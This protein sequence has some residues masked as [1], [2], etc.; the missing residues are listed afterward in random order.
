MG[1]NLVVPLFLL[2][3]IC[4]KSSLENSYFSIK[5]RVLLVPRINFF[6][7]HQKEVLSTFFFAETYNSEN[8]CNM[9]VCCMRY[10]KSY[11]LIQPV[12][13][14]C[15]TLLPLLKNSAQ[16]KFYFEDCLLSQKRFSIVELIC[17]NI[18]HGIFQ[19]RQNPVRNFRKVIYR[20]PLQTDIKRF[21]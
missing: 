11:P 13:R 17:E 16:L 7:I 9:L 19:G 5:E 10:S 18:S 3:N 8:C 20:S 4:E 2:T 1:L 12:S 14:P 21:R 6:L 15:R